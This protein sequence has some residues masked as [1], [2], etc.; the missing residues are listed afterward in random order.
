MD[1]LILVEAGWQDRVRDKLGVSDVY[2]PDSAVE[3]FEAVGLAERYMV[4]R[5]PHHADLGADEF[6]IL[7][8]AA[9]SECARLLCPTMKARLPKRQ[10]GLHMELT[11]ETDW[12]QRKKELEE[13]RETILSYIDIDGGKMPFFETT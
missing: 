5:V 8:S 6:R 4:M 10:E 2:L 7:Q 11:L 9:V 12:D 3:Q 1:N 13:E